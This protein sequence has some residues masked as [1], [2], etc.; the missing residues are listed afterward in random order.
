[1]QIAVVGSG[2]MGHGIAEVAAM[3]GMEVKLIDISWDILNKA[4]ERMYDSLKRLHERGT[5]KETPDSVLSRVEMST[6]YEIARQS[7]FAI[8]QFR[9][10]WT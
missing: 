9:R 4:K 2:T 5:I 8:E 6:S 10:Y 1:M 7:D 3:A